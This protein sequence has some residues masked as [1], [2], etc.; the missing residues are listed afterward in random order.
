MASD[1]S[2]ASW[3][4]LL[5]AIV[6]FII[7]IIIKPSTTSQILLSFLSL[8]QKIA[9]IFLIV[10]LLMALTNYFFEPKKLIKHLGKGSGI[11]GWF[12]AIGA[13]IIS[14]GPIYMWYPL[15]ADLKE[16]GMKLS[17]IACF[18]YNRAIKIPLIP[19]M[20]FYFDFKYVLILTVVMIIMSVANG[21]IVEA[22]LNNKK[23][24]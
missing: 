24:K 19:I 9:P 18:L 17:L 10:F 11:K 3:Y 20:I 12:I 4:F 13:G 8:L 16:K 1:K 6:I 22:I 7:T 15:L 23:K 21:I 5:I 14:H 2:N